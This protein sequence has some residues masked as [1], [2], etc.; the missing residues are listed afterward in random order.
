[1]FIPHGG[2]LFSGVFFAVFNRNLRLNTAW[3]LSARLRRK[4][5]SSLLFMGPRSPSI[6]LWSILTELGFPP[7][8]PTVLHEDN[9]AAIAMINECKPT[10]RSGHIDIQHFEIQEWQRN[11]EIIM[12]YIPT[13]INPMDQATMNLGWTLPHARHARRLMGHYGY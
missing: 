1:M 13:T 3:L 9:Q 8:G 10:P 12:R 11:R 6:Y 5:N 4:L 2:A 7:S